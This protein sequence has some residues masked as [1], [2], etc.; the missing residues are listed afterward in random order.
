MRS[1]RAELL[2][3]STEADI[4]LVLRLL[5]DGAGIDDV[6]VPHEAL[7]VLR[8]NVRRGI[9]CPVSDATLPR[10]FAHAYSALSGRDRI[11]GWFAR[12]CGC[13]RASPVKAADGTRTPRPSAW[14]F[15]P[16]VSGGL[17]WFASCP[18]N[19][20]ISA[21]AAGRDL[22]P[23]PGCLSPSCCPGVAP[24]ERVSGRRRNETT[25][26]A[27]ERGARLWSCPDSS[28]A[29]EEQRRS[30]STGEISWSMNLARVWLKTS[31]S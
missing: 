10:A 9:R 7:V 25:A 13:L 20:A 21:I 2:G 22:R 16:R 24:S 8:G 1:S 29:R 31:G 12:L 3:S 5:A 11:P 27:Q 19:P 6:V 30:Q 26:S 23:Y 17:R 15:A 4:C 14:Q 28:F 18:A